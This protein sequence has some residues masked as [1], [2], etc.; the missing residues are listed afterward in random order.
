[1]ICEYCKQEHNG[2]YGS[3]RFCSKHCRMAYIGSKCNKN[4][5]LTGHRPFNKLPRAPY[6]TW[7]CKFCGVI[8]DTKHLL[9]KH[10]HAA[11]CDLLQQKYNKGGIAWNKGLTAETDSR[12]ALGHQKLMDKYK[13][14][15][16]KGSWCG[17][18]H[19]EKSKKQMSESALKSLHQRI[20]KKTLP[21]KKPDGTIINLDSS[22]ERILAEWLDKNNIEWT[23]PEP[24]NWIDTNGISHHYFPDFYIPS[25]DLYL[26]PKN[27]YC[28]NAQKEKIQYIL[29][30]YPNVK[31]LHEKDLSSEKLNLILG[32]I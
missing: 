18:H 19:T 21:Y 9:Y 23:R 24:L 1:M 20:C 14:G 6:G 25:K 7:K 28:F 29:N 11:H 2:S 32:I 3:G 30:H 10:Y 8:F 16:L 22:Y 15:E 12:V 31:F 27:E 4:G 13:S 5:K 26:D 17:R